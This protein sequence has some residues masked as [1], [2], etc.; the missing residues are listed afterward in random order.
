M[1]RPA[2][3]RIVKGLTTAALFGPSVDQFTESVPARAARLV[4]RV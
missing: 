4:I 3:E 2:V 1:L